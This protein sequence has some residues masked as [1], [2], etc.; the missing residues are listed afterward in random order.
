[1]EVIMHSALQEWP[2]LKE[3]EEIGH[4]IDQPD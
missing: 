2:V 1:M 3:L 4:G